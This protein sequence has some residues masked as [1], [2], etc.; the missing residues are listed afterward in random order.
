MRHVEKE[1]ICEIFRT[2][3]SSMGVSQ[4]ADCVSRAIIE[5]QSGDTDTLTAAH[6]EAACD[7]IQDDIIDTQ[8]R[9]RILEKTCSADDLTHR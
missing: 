4:I 2:K 3:F 8:H 1:E 7:K 9:R 6:F 5:M